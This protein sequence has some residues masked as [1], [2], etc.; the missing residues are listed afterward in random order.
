M[1]PKPQVSFF[2]LRQE[3]PALREYG[4]AAVRYVP[5][6]LAD[7]FQ[8]FLQGQRGCPRYKSKYRMTDGFTLAQ[9]V[10]IRDGR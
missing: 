1:G 7:A 3:F 10:K 9:N 2:G 8:A 6:Y 4:R 5:K